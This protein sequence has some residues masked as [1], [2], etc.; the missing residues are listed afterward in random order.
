MNPYLSHTLLLAAME[1]GLAEQTDPGAPQ[2]LSSYE[3]KADNPFEPLPTTL[4][5]AIRAFAAD[6]LVTGALGQELSDLLIEY[7]TDEWLRYCGVVSDW[8]RE[9]YLEFMP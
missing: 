1:E 9:M 4:G 2:L 5:D 3:T 8:E 7:K 6:D